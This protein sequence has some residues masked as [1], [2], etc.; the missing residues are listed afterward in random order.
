MLSP[1][2][3]TY[4]ASRN[5]VHADSDEDRDDLRTRVSCRKLVF[6]VSGGHPIEGSGRCCQQERSK[7]KVYMQRTLRSECNPCRTVHR[8]T[9]RFRRPADSRRT[10]SGLVSSAFGQTSTPP[11]ESGTTPQAQGDGSDSTGKEGICNGDDHID[12]TPE[13]AGTT[14]HA[15]ASATLEESSGASSRAPLCITVRIADSTELPSTPA[16]ATVT[17]RKKEPTVRWTVSPEPTIHRDMQSNF[18]TRNSCEN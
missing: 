4:P 10:D 1:L 7:M 15:F 16:G 14:R 3:S 18:H 11:Q 9:P 13:D 17:P 5:S 2:L 12:P 6:G 8:N